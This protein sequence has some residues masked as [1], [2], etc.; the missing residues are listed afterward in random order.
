[1]SEQPVEAKQFSFRYDKTRADLLVGYA[2]AT[3]RNITDVLR[4]A[5]DEYYEKH[6]K[7]I[8]KRQV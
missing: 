3:R 1:M 5:L 7:T 4:E 6:K 2:F 8:H